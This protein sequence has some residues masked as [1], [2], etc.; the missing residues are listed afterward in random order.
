MK[1]HECTIG[2][3]VELPTN[4]HC[5]NNRGIGVIRE[6]AIVDQEV[7]I[8]VETPS[9]HLPVVGGSSTSPYTTLP[10]LS[11]SLYKCFP[12]DL[13]IPDY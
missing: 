6:L 10:A 8:V 13:S 3:V 9:Q 7:M 2:R 1:L 5:P 12:E 11:G 4:L